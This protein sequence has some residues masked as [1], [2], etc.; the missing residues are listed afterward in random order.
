MFT[1][2]TLTV[3]CFLLVPF[4]IVGISFYFLAWF[5][6]T[7]TGVGPLAQ[8]LLCK[9]DR[10]LLDTLLK[11]HEG[12]VVEMVPVPTGEDGHKQ[13]QPPRRLAVRWSP[14]KPGGQLPPVVIPNGLGATLITI[15]SL[16]DLLEA[17]GYPVL[18]YDRAGV[19]QSD[20]LRPG[21]DAD[22]KGVDVLLADL[23]FLMDRCVPPSEG[24]QWIM[25]GPSMGSLV[26][27]CYM[28]RYPGEACGFVNVDG[29]PYPFAGKR[30]KFVAASPTASM[31][32]SLLSA[33]QRAIIEVAG[34]DVGNDFG[35]AYDLA[36]QTVAG[37]PG[38]GKNVP[39][40][41]PPP[42]VA[43]PLRPPV[44]QPYEAQRLE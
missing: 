17:R 3:I 35:N 28:A 15:A 39:P 20:P 33:I 37:A 27:Q 21:E 23:K 10:R 41:P 34:A 42:P 18:S 14:G 38:G 30:G 8:H 25:V 43:L 5:L 31:A 2:A 4:Y 7:V 22:G 12:A 1:S 29:L 24:K 19:G 44:A 36:M 13:P 26:C 40:Q 32:P 9:R 16:H 11:P 6:L